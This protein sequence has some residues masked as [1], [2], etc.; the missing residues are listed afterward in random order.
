[1]VTGRGKENLVPRERDRLSPQKGPLGIERAQ[2]PQP[3]AFLS[4]GD[5]GQPPRQLRTLIRTG[6]L[7]LP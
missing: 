5:L 6:R 3:G 7:G 2:N 1:M 4:R